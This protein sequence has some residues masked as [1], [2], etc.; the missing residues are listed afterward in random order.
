MLVTGIILFYLNVQ[1]WIFSS[2]CS[3]NARLTQI[4]LLFSIK[5]NLTITMKKVC[6]HFVALGGLGR[7]YSSRHQRHM[8]LYRRL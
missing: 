2:I 5:K 7:K 8:K 3:Q 6:T 4:P 1:I